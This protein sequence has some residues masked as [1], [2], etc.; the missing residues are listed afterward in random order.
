MNSC[1]GLNGWDWL[2]ELMMLSH[3]TARDK[4]MVDEALAGG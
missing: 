1:S 2:W 4:G 3:I